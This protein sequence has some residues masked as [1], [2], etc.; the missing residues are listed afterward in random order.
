MSVEVVH[1]LACPATAIAPPG[2][3][4][5]VEAP[6]QEVEGLVGEDDSQT[7]CHDKA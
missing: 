2:V 6:V 5:A 7:C 4:V 3:G 1:F